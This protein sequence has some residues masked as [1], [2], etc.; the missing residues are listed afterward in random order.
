MPGASLT[1]IT[2]RLSV[3]TGLS[4]MLVVMT[5][6][7]HAAAEQPVDSLRLRDSDHS[8]MRAD[9]FD[10]TAPTDIRFDDQQVFSA[11][12]RHS[13][14]VENMSAQHPPRW[15]SASDDMSATGPPVVLNY[16]DGRR[17][18]TTSLA[19]GLTGTGASIFTGALLYHLETRQLRDQ[20]EEVSSTLRADRYRDVGKQV[21][22]ARKIVLT[23]YAVGGSM[24]TGG[25]VLMAQQEHDGPGIQ[26]KLIPAWMNGAPAARLKVRF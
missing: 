22:Q 13:A 16:D 25:V 8:A 5:F 15:P 17:S 6:A 11:S 7:S 9:N 12:G 14:M 10:L 3:L 26:A 21:D 20:S 24:V 23:L 18:D 1:R 2:E 19:W 4:V